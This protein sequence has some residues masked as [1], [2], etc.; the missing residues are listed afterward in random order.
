MAT[1]YSYVQLMQLKCITTNDD[2]D[3]THIHYD[4]S[5][6]NDDNDVDNRLTLRQTSHST[7][8]LHFQ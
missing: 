2:D 1:S 3:D 6:D 5:D 8:N 7:D 4:D